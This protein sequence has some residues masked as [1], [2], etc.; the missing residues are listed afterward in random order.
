MYRSRI[1]ADVTSTDLHAGHT[2]PGPSEKHPVIERDREIAQ[3]LERT[4]LHHAHDV[5]APW[6]GDIRIPDIGEVA[7]APGVL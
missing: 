1:V 5:I 7:G 3:G 4:H 2:R 6:N